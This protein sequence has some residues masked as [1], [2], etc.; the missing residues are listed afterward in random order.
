MG[1]KSSSTV[2]TEANL[3]NETGQVS[4]REQVHVCSV[5]SDS[6]IPWTVAYQAP[7]SIEF[8]RQKYWS[9]FPFPSPFCLLTPGNFGGQVRELDYKE[10]IVPKN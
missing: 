3:G 10:S 5:M 2:E 4:N 7:P 8:S 1:I 9:G 6:A